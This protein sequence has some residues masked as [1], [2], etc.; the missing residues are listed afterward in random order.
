[1]CY[2]FMYSFH[3]GNIEVFKRKMLIRQFCKHC[4]QISLPSFY[5]IMGKLNNDENLNVL[6]T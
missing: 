2:L 1:M 3:L 4:V 5:G 6:Q